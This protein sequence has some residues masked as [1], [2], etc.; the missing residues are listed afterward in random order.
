RVDP[1]L[2]LSLSLRFE[3]RISDRAQRGPTR[4]H[5]IHERREWE[6]K[7]ESVCWSRHH[8]RRAVR[9]P[10]SQVVETRNPR[11]ERLLRNKPRET[12]LGVCLA[13]KAKSERRASV[14][15]D[16]T[17]EENSFVESER[18]LD[19]RPRDHRLNG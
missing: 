9:D 12:R 13:V 5:A 11:N 7:R 16:R 2:E 4:E 10:E 14:G 8:T 15:A 3:I 17:G 18:L 1:G 19:I 6:R